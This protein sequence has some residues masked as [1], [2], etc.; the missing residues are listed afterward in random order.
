MGKIISFAN[1]KG[2]VGK[3]TLNMLFADYLHSIKEYQVCLLDLDYKQSSINNVRKKEKEK[4]VQKA[5]ERWESDPANPPFSNPQRIKIE[6]IF[7]DS[8]YGV[9]AKKA[10]ELKKL[11]LDAVVE[12]YD[13]VVIDFPGSLD[14][15]GVIEFYRLVDYL[16]AVTSPDP[17][18]VDGTEIY[19]DTYLKE[20]K[21]IRDNA[22]IKTS[23]YGVANQIK[24]KTY[25]YKEF[26]D[27]KESFKIPFLE[28]ELP[29]ITDMK[30]V[31]TF[32]IN[33]KEFSKGSVMEKFC[34]E[35]FAIIK[36]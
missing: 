2:G 8:T 34:E 15:P 26:S 12:N 22:G 17:M 32:E 33:F 3:T 5:K 16:F 6:K 27:K 29:D 14:A 28:N 35:V 19:I 20:V 1:V 36:K 7:D 9:I 30:R 10:D 24:K 25:E 21:P 31:T 13:Y 11:N 23:F 4:F 18:D